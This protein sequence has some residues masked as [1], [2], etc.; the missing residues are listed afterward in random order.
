MNTLEFLQR[1]LPSEGFYV[2]TVINGPNPTD[3]K[4]G[5][6]RTVDELA[7]VCVRLDQ[8]GNNTYFAVASFK[9]KGSR[10]Q[11]N[12]QFMR[13]VA[14]DVDCGEGKP[15]ATQ[16][17]GLLALSKFIQETNLPRPM[18][19]SSGRG[20]HVY[21]VF[22]H[23]LTI[24]E[25]YPMA[26]ALKNAAAAKGFAFDPTVPADCAR[27]MRPVGTRN[28]KNNKIVSVLLDAVD[29]TVDMFTAAMKSFM[30]PVAP[31]TRQMGKSTL[32]D[33]L[34][35]KQDYP[36]AVPHVVKHKCQQIDWMVDNQD[37]VTEPQWYNLIG[38]AA[39]CLDPEATA[40]EWSKGHPKYDEAATLKKLAQWKAST[41]GPSTCAKFEADRP[42]GCKGCKFRGNISTP[43]RLGV[44]HKEIAPPIVAAQQTANLIQLPKPFKRT[45]DGIKVTIDDTD[46]DVCPFDIIPVGY[47]KDEGLGYE[48]V[49]YLW[50][51][52]HVGWSPLTLRQAYLTDGHREFAGC[53]ADQG[54][55]LYSKR[56]TE[57]FQLM[58]RT[59][60]E[61]LR[62]QQTMTN[63]YSTMGWKE[64]YKR[65]VI[66]DT[67]IKLNAD[68]TVQ[69]ETITLA[70][71][72]QRVGQELY[73]AAG[74]LQAWTNMT[75]LFDKVNMPWHGFAL[76]VGLSAPLYAFTGLKGSTLSLYGPTGGGKSLAQLWVQS[77]W[78]D[79]DKLHVTAKFTQNMLFSRLGLYS[80]M[81]MTIDEVTMVPD[82][83][84][85]D[86]C[87]W[88]SQGRDK[89]RLNRA[90]EER[91]A[92]TWATPVIVSTN[93]SWQSKLI[94]SGLETD[95]QMARLLELSIPVHP[96]FT[97]GTDA[98]RKIYSFLTTN[99]GYAGRE[100][101]K[102]LVAAGE[103][104]IRAMIA[105]HTEKFTARHGGKFS[106]E[107]RYWEQ[108]VVLADLAGM[109]AKNWG[110]I[111][112]NPE[113]STAWVLNQLGALRKAQGDNRTDAFDALSEYLNEHAATAIMVTHTGS[114]TPLPDYAR[115]PKADVRIRFDLYRNA[116]NAQFDKGT[117]MLD[118]A[119]FRKWLSSVGI[120]Y[121]QFVNELLAENVI[122]TPKS[123]KFYL[124]KDTPIKVGQTYVIG[125]NLNHPRLQGILNDADAN[126]DVML[127]APLR[128]V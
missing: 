8:T 89:A 68:N 112:F 55:V 116:S 92:K 56:Q 80:N 13:V 22:D 30:G 41:T 32:L 58:M 57:Y 24:Q 102:N 61:K 81:P 79:P 91:D 124:G 119:H 15:F 82:K 101:M 34:A 3:R 113:K 122:A 93:K 37:K 110:L 52:P 51:R 49:R 100:F 17:E 38:I 48:T 86:F 46:I 10:K 7:K 62:Q 27:V 50:N 97:A 98:G 117:V 63:L 16:R 83:E 85:G 29:I 106:G 45:A 67:V 104:A 12:A 64:D 26:V 65:F 103:G 105:E 73:G 47:G 94:A 23:D 123:G 84:V 1:V 109:L 20:L 28:P 121:R 25:W 42:S 43:A 33:S 128:A 69:E 5:F 6:F 74:S 71:G 111:S 95:A 126:I 70:S 2:T 9:E 87:Y 21:W 4:Q 120:D 127:G 14:A 60:M 107:E 35:V 114:S 77:I 31:P 11:T 66:G 99:Y 88:V 118:R 39:H 96:M 125:V 59:Y 53:I 40:I 78:G 76:L 44:Q 54:I 108:M 75:S 90:A 72:A 19:V 36:P 115:M 18:I